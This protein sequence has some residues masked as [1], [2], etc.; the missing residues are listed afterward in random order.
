MEGQ[1]F[2]L[3]LIRGYSTFEESCRFEGGIADAGAKAARVYA[4]IDAFI[5]EFVGWTL[6]LINDLLDGC[7]KQRLWQL[8]RL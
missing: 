8:I 7:Q 2:V 3:A 5:V 6:L 4:I 1:E